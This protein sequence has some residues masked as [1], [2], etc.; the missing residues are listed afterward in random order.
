MFFRNNLHIVLCMSPVGSAFRTR[1]RMFPSLVNCCTIDWFTEWPKEAL[2]S[3]STSFFESV[4]IGT[5]EIKVRQVFQC[6]FFCILKC[7]VFSNKT[8]KTLLIVNLKIN[9]Y[10]LGMKVYLNWHNLEKGHKHCQT[11]INN[12]HIKLP[13]L[14]TMSE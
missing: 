2:Y 7:L 12:C 13:F 9:H 3:V 8:N 4:Q 11:I 5:D 1:C 10:S 14:V 6:G